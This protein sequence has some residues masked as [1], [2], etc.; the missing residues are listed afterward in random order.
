[1]A[2]SLAHVG[3]HPGLLSF[4]EPQSNLKFDQ[5]KVSGISEVTQASSVYSALRWLSLSLSLSLSPLPLPQTC[6]QKTGNCE[7]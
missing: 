5:S 3:E 7:L 6:I 1:M 2:T 4:Y